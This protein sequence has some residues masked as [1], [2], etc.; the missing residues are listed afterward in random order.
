MMTFID[1]A[2]HKCF[3]LHKLQTHKHLHGNKR[4]VP[5]LLGMDDIEEEHW[6]SNKWYRVL[7]VCES[8]YVSK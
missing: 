6:S 3:P 1:L 2:I 8:I 5:V 4:L 7:S